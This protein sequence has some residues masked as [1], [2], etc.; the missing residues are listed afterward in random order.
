MKWIGQHIWDFISR[1]RSDV[2]LEATETGT[3]T[4]GGNLG[5]DSNNKIVKADTES[6]ELS[7][8]G[9]TA[10]GVCTFKDADE[11]SVESTWTYDGSITSMA[12]SSSI[13][14]LLPY[15][16]LRSSSTHASSG[17]TLVFDKDVAGDDDDIV[18]NIAFNGEDDGGGSNNFAQIIA[19]IADATAGQ[20]AGKL[21]L[22]VSEYDGT[23]T[24][25]VTLDGDTNAD[26]EVDVTIG[27]GAAS[28]TTVAGTLTMGSTAFA[29]NS[30]VVQVATQ[31]TIDHDSLANFV[32]AEH[33][34]WASDISGTATIHTNNI[35]DLHGA[36]VDGSASQILTDDGDGSVTSH[37]DFYW[38]SEVMTLGN[39]D[40][41]FVDIRRKAHSDGNAG[42][43]R[44]Y[45]GSATSGQTD[46]NGG[47]M[48]F[49]GGAPTGNGTFGDFTFWGG[50]QGVSGTT[51]RSTSRTAMLTTSGSTSTDFYMFEA[52][53]ASLVDYFKISVR[54]NGSTTLSTVDDNAAVADLTLSADG[55][56]EFNSA[57]NKINK[58]YDFHATTFENTYSDDQGAGTILKYSPGADESPAGSELFFLHTDGTW[59][60]TDAD[61]VATGASQLL[62]VGLG[63]SARTTGVLIK[64]FVRIASTEIL[65]T[66]GSGAV[67]GLPVYVST[68]A[69][70]FDFTAPSG[71]SDF[72]R[73][74]GYAID[75]DSSDVLIYFDPDKTWVEIA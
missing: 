9:S 47:G 61:A 44:F 1:F 4:S 54:S 17:P 23:L 37:S 19:R 74:V 70:H 20:E 3:I 30:G 65:N 34:A 25:G 46:H 32:A 75:D 33:Y 6:G 40:N 24:A 53:G 55:G 50:V 35:T 52:A 58:I 42:G 27:A 67:D 69:G 29:N 18:G 22:K 56:V 31:G 63:A 12:I 51:L 43:F 73:I 45:G 68:T 21:E 15:V 49:I 7:F 72:V 38:G 26:G 28:V 59:N 64:G 36:G 14:G 10:N 60:Q 2:Y 11:I 71:S 5:L 57:T 16:A 13:T 39:D 66:P 48:N 41:G 8:D 62:G